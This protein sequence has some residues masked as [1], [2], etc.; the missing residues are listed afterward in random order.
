M[1]T[2][3]DPHFPAPLLDTPPDRNCIELSGDAEGLLRGA[4]L[5]VAASAEI[6]SAAR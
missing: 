3:D 4:Q 6:S 5:P 1:T 2:V